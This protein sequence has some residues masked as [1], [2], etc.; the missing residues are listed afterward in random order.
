MAVRNFY[1]E[2][3]IE[4]RETMLG[5]GPRN[6]EGGM[7]TNIYQRDDGGMYKSL[8]QSAVNTTASLLQ[9][10]LIKTEIKFILMKARD[11]QWIV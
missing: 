2:A 9:K 7:T 11:K 8:K 4:G 1:V 6:E 10:S 3:D 5:G